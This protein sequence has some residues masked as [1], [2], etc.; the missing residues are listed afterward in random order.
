VHIVQQILDDFHS[1]KQNLAQFHINMK[2]RFI[3][4]EYYALRSEN[5]EY[6]GTLEVSQD[7]TEKRQLQG[8]KRLLSYEEG[9]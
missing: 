1:G 4:I 7:L 3:C 9:K 6:L 2:G 8:D 5:G